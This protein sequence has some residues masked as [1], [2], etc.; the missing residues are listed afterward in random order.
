[1]K[2][3]CSEKGL[4]GYREFEDRAKTGT[5]ARGRAGFREMIEYFESGLAQREGV[6]GLLLWCF[7]RFAREQDDFQ[8]Y[9]SSIRRAGYTVQSLTDQIP[10]GDFGRFFEA[11]VSWKD[12]QFSR[13][14][15][16]HVKRGQSLVLNNYR[17]DGELYE[18]P[19]GERVQLSA[20][21]APP[22]GY[23]R[24]PVA[25]G[26]T[27]TGTARYNTYWRKTVDEDLARRVRL[28]WEMMLGGAS[29]KEI[30]E[31]CRL[32]L[33]KNSY[34]DFFQTETYTGTY[35]YG[36]FV[37]ERAFE[38]YVTKE[39]FELV[40]A[41]IG[42]RNTGPKPTLVKYL[43][44][45]LVRCG[46]CGQLWHG[47]RATR[48][49]RKVIYYYECGSRNRL[50]KACGIGRIRAQQL[51]SLVL[52]A[53]VEAF[54]PAKIYD[55][56][57]QLE[58]RWRNERERNVKPVEKLEKIVEGETGIIKSLALQLVTSA[59]RLGIEA[60]IERM[61]VEARVRRDR[62]Q[63]ELDKL[64]VGAEQTSN[65]DIDIN[66]ERVREIQ[67]M[68]KGAVK[69]D[70]PSG[71]I[72]EVEVFQG[73]RDLLYLFKVSAMIYADVE[74]GD[75]GSVAV[76]IDLGS[77]AYKNDIVGFSP[78]MSSLTEGG[79]TWIRTRDLSI[80]SRLR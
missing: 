55:L 79:P 36:D 59:A 5:K 39:E 10:E 44:G 8:F 21:G 2:K 60:D 31:G 33:G 32:G 52:E 57:L 26:R 78:A 3:A 16:K 68:L 72:D 40:Q 18:L 67:K 53:L 46:T 54:E 4:V 63:A 12:A 1:W 27:R 7:S 29:Y 64:K 34:N 20:G 51:E 76:S 77:M 24:V 71:L 73:I 50:M 9:I 65:T 38:A 42:G 66:F 25:T 45:G 28:A 47:V 80:M 11:L 23:E 13:D 75:K 62:A 48:E 41:K 22:L 49:G 35:M 58:T 19:T 37:R 14:L 61:I 69:Q 17:D 6:R 15:S 70:K 74:N 30:E 56:A 43:L